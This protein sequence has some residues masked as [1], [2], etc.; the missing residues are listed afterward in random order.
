MTP[1]AKQVTKHEQIIRSGEFM[2]PLPDE[3]TGPCG[4]RENGIPCHADGLAL[5]ITKHDG[6]KGRL[7]ACVKHAKQYFKFIAPEGKA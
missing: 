5:Q 1:D 4:C 7:Y 3:P 6:R 2:V